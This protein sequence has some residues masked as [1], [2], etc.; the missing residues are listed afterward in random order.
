[1][2]LKWLEIPAGK[3]EVMAVETWAVR[4]QSWHAPYN[5][6][7]ARPNPE[8]EVFTSK[9][10]AEEFANTLKLAAN[11]LKNKVSNLVIRIEEQK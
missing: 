1:M 3:K 5:D 9:Q 8:I 7:Y 4:W 2:N 10:A 11:L 6:S